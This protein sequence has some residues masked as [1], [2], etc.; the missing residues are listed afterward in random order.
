MDMMPEL[1]PDWTAVRTEEPVPTQGLWLLGT[2]GHALRP[3]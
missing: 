1:L 2:Q 3:V